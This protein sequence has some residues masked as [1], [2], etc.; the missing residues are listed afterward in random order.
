MMIGIEHYIY[1]NEED[2]RLID[3]LMKE[4]NGYKKVIQ[5]WRDE[6]DKTYWG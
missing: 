4:N 3:E 6:A 2:K 5:K 1:R